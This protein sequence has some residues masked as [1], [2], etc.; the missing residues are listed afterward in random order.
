MFSND[1]TIYFVYNAQKGFHFSIKDFFHKSLA[2]NKYPCSL[3]EKTY[4][5]L[6]KKKKWKIYLDQLE[7][8]YEFVYLN[9][10]DYLFLN[11]YD[12]YPVILIGNK[13]NADILLSK[14]NIDNCNT[15]NE[16]MLLIN[17]KL[18]IL[19]H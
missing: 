18:K 13:S 3:C 10:S 8:N 9:Q 14:D 2:P 1:N 11:Q 16:L 12:N 7:F 4:G 6:T 15:L 17:Q 19:N 5:F